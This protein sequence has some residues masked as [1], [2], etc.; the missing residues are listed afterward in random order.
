MVEF[1]FSL[2]VGTGIVIYNCILV[3]AVEQREKH[4]DSM[5]GN[6]EL[7]DW[8]HEAT[9]TAADGA[10]PVL[11][12]RRSQSIFVAKEDLHNCCY[13]CLSPV[14]H[15]SSSRRGSSSTEV[16]LCGSDC[17]CCCCEGAEAFNSCS[18][19]FKDVT[20]SASTRGTWVWQAPLLPC[21]TPK[22]HVRASSTGADVAAA[23]VC[24][25]TTRVRS[26]AW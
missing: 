22:L 8:E 4:R 5:R 15:S 20:H 2:C 21:D 13:S 24:E 12:R 10:K 7:L 6:M 26:A 19:L 16:S 11:T 14:H 23:A 3:A 25:R 9:A 1:L 18:V 17:G